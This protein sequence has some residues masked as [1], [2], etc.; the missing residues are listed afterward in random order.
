M[1]FDETSVTP[2]VICDYFHSETPILESGGTPDYADGSCMIMADA[3]SFLENRGLGIHEVR[4]Y[5]FAAW[6]QFP[7]MEQAGDGYWHRPLDAGHI[8]MLLGF[9]ARR[10]AS[11]AVS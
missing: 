4:E 3:H 5:S 7:D 6:P 9:K 8:T 1:I 2:V 11:G 10:Q